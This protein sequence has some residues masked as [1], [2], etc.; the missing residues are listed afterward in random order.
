MVKHS[1]IALTNC[2]STVL[3]LLFGFLNLNKFSALPLGS[4]W[5]LAMHE[6]IGREGDGVIFNAG[7]LLGYGVL[8]GSRHQ[9]ERNGQ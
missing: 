5:N 3:G 8:P 1:N 2:S 6:K 9:I 7:D 4:V